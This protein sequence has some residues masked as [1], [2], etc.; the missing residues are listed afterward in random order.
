M[1]NVRLVYPEMPSTLVSRPGALLEPSIIHS[2]IHST[3]LSDKI[4]SSEQDRAAQKEYWKRSSG[5]FQAHEHHCSF[6]PPGQSGAPN[7][8]LP[9]WPQRSVGLTESSDEAEIDEV[10]DVA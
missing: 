8:V 7:P 1:Q 6:V 9:V 2:L 5:V 4:L 10:E 3:P